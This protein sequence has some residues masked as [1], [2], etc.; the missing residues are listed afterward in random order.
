MIAKNAERFGPIFIEYELSPAIA[1]CICIDRG[2]LNFDILRPSLTFSPI[3]FPD[4]FFSR[5]QL[6]SLVPDKTYTTLSHAALS[7]HTQSMPT[8]TWTDLR[9]VWNI[10]LVSISGSFSDRREE[11]REQARGPGIIGTLEKQNMEHWSK[12]CAGGKNRIK[13]PREAP[14]AILKEQKERK[15]WVAHVF[16]AR[17]SQNPE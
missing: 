12:P 13:Y 2:G 6:A 10:Q 17:K 15:K 4:G 16:T 5:G 8:G 1:C 9:V 7:I 14:S 3:R 11:K